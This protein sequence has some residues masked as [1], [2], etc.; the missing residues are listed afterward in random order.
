M[1]VMPFVADV[2]EMM[3][4]GPPANFS[5]YPTLDEP[6]VPASLSSPSLSPSEGAHSASWI[7]APEELLAPAPS[8]SRGPHHYPRD[9]RSLHRKN[10]STVSQSNS[11][12]PPRMDVSPTERKERS[13]SPKKEKKPSGSMETKNSHASTQ[14]LDVY[15]ER[16][17]QGQRESRSTSPRKN[18]R[19]DL[20]TGTKQSSWGQD[21]PQWHYTGSVG[22]Q[23][24]RHGE[25]SNFQQDKE[26]GETRPE[27]TKTLNERRRREK[28]AD[29]D[30]A[31]QKSHSHIHRERPI[32]EP[33]TSTLNRKEHREKDRE[34]KEQGRHKGVA[35]DDSKRETRGSSSVPPE[36]S[37]NGNPSTKK[38]PITPGPWKVPSSAKIHS[39]V[40]GVWR[41]LCSQFIRMPRTPEWA[42]LF[43]N[44]GFSESLCI[45]CIFFMWLLHPVVTFAET[46]HSWVIQCSQVSVQIL[47][48]DV[49]VGAV[50]SPTLR[51]ASLIL[52]HSETPARGTRLESQCSCETLRGVK[53]ECSEIS[54]NVKECFFVVFFFWLCSFSVHMDSQFHLARFARCPYKVLAETVQP[55]NAKMV[56]AEWRLLRTPLALISCLTHHHCLTE[57]KSSPDRWADTQRAD[58][59]NPD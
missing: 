33:Q 53:M 27:N 24:W 14:S 3:M 6:T 1:T 7:T 38:A 4:M 43:S 48:P 50:V 56:Q 42:R 58:F 15:V 35:A 36:T 54:G 5:R 44:D 8:S 23:D 28:G 13:R 16:K 41:G 31:P 9:P 12:G 10:D 46:V 2:K 49:Q 29:N 20:E 47:C 32:P 11:Q 39:Q 40:E 17:P 26:T 25:S 59:P 34:V 45:R 18:S 19:K 57:L 51:P 52:C 30:V 37:W 21:E 22:P 55:S